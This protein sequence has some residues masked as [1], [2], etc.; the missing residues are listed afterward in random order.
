LRE[1][2]V[3]GVSDGETAQ[4]YSVPKLRYHEVANTVIGGSAIA[5]GY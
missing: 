2:R 1:G 5:V 3:I 4:A